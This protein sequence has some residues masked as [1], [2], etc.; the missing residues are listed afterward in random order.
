MKTWS[1]TGTGVIGRG[2]LAGPVAEIRAAK[3]A[4][5]ARPLVLEKGASLI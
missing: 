4:E 2:M 3:V 5:R 1:V